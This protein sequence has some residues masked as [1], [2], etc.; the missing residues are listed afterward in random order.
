MFFTCKNF[1]FSNFAWKI[2]FAA[3]NGEGGRGLVLPL[4]LLLYGTGT[5]YKNI[6]SNI[7]SNVITFQQCNGIFN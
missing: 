4:P 2:I 7:K 3:E 6:V 1:I 5:R